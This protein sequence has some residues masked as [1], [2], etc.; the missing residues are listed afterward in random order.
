MRQERDELS[1]FEYCT[2]DLTQNIPDPLCDC[3]ST[4]ISRECI[5]N[6]TALVTYC[7]N[8]PYCGPDSEEV[9]DV[10][11][12]ICE[13]EWFCN[14]YTECQTDGYQ[15]C[16]DVYDIHSC[17]DCYL[18]DYSEFTEACSYCAIHGPV[19]YAEDKITV[20]E[21][22]LVTL[23]VEVT[24]PDEDTV[25]YTISSPVGN[26]GEWQTK[27]GDEGNYN[28]VITASD[29]F[30][31][32][33]KVVKIIVKEKPYQSLIIERTAYK[34]FIRPGDYQELYVTLE[35]MGNIDIKDLKIT[36]FIDTLGVWR[37]TPKFNIRAGDERTKLIQFMVP[38]DAM[39]GRHY[40]RIVISNDNIRRVIYRDFD[41]I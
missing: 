34:E 26:D 40:M 11:C 18:G 39:P 33:E 23:D 17:G 14:A 12:W 36:A 24:D 13:P 38:Y 27:K 30:C 8:Y 15:Y 28:V 3:I 10:A 32:T 1:G 37:K 31:T 5:A 19:I 16:T 9:Y 22:Q 20:F 25:I 41:V 29:G 6:V 21:E 4:E 2:D 35:N 7:W